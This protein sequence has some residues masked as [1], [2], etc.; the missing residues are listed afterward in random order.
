MRISLVLGFALLT[1]GC[2]RDVPQTTTAPAGEPAK[3]LG[4]PVLNREFANW[5]R[6][7]IGTTVKTKSVTQKGDLHV[8]SVETLRL[9]EKSDYEIVVERQ[10]TTERNDGSHGAVNPPERRKYHKSFSLPAGMSESDFAKPAL[11]AKSAAN[12]TIE[13]LGKKY[14][15]EVFT[16]TDQTESGPLE[17]KLW[18]SDEMPGRLLKQTIT[19]GKG[20]KTTNESVIELMLPDS[21]K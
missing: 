10:N 13:I 17:I 12:E 2:G 11:K 5:S 14:N 8:T 18:R 9:I 6:F 20:D 21:M 3:P 1:L 4:P 16:W 7:P 15:A 19:L